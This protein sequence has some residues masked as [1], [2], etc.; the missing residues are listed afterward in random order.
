LGSNIK[1]ILLESDIFVTVFTEFVR[2][3]K[4]LFM[5]RIVPLENIFLNVS[6]NIEL[7]FLS[8]IKLC[9]RDVLVF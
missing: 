3:F 2:I 5:G 6:D 9:L 8:L 4:I 7:I 1:I